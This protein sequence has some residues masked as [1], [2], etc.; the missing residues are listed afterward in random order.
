MTA[1]IALHTLAARV[2]CWGNPPASGSVLM[3][4]NPISFKHV[5]PH[6][7][8]TEIH[9]YT[10]V[11]RV[12]RLLDECKEISR[13]KGL[14]HLGALSHALPG[15]RHTRWDYTV[16]LLYYAQSLD[17]PGMKSAFINAAIK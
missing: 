11:D 4:E 1:L 9:L 3:P 6:V 14:R 8:P 2:I 7:G 13:L 10:P 5:I 12:Y 17:L 15:T 16:A